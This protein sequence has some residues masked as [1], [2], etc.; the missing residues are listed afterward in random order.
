[1]TRS[2]FT[3]ALD[4]MSGGDKGVAASLTVRLSIYPRIYPCIWRL[5]TLAEIARRNRNMTDRQDK[6][7]TQV[8]ET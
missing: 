7:H 8:L 5:A 1:M 6:T 2:I 4:S 3:L